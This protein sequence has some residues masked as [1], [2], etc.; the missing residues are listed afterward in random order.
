MIDEFASE[1][2]TKRTK[3]D[4]NDLEQHR[5]NWLSL[6]TLRGPSS[7]FGL[8]H[9]TRPSPLQLQGRRRRRVGQ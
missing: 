7:R 1:P 8:L 6:Q 5:V 2:P 9:I 4:C 3:Q